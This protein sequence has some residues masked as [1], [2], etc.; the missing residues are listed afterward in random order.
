MKITEAFIYYMCLNN[1]GILTYVNEPN[2]RILNNLMLFQLFFLPADNG[3]HSIF[4]SDTDL[5]Y[6]NEYSP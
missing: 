1:L 4:N 3:E 5:W 2:S 6:A